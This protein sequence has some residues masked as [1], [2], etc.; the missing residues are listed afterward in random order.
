MTAELPKAKFS[1]KAHLLQKGLGCVFLFLTIVTVT[2]MMSCTPVITLIIGSTNPSFAESL[3]TKKVSE[4]KIGANNEAIEGR[5]SEQLLDDRQLNE[6]PAKYSLASVHR[7]SGFQIIHGEEAGEKILFYNI[8]GNRTTNITLEVTQAPSGW[9]V[10]IT[11]NKLQIEPGELSNQPIEDV[12][13]DM[14]YLKVGDRGYTLAT[15]AIITVQ[16][17]QDELVT[18]GSIRIVAEA[19]WMGQVG[20]VSIRQTRQFDF[21]IALAKNMNA[22]YQ[23]V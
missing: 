17:P 8:D 3:V 6:E 18:E 11:N 2:L 12:P 9:K 5:V 16:I 19:N 1:F 10:D 7:G 20:Q 15:V 4:L 13:D 14:I 22:S 23:S 21:N